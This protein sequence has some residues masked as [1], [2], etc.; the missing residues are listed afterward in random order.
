MRRE[1]DPLMGVAAGEYEHRN[2]Q[3]DRDPHSASSSSIIGPPAPLVTALERVTALAMP[4]DGSLTL[5]HVR[6]IDPRH[7]SAWHAADAA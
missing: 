1:I 2:R 5:S 7:L 4:R 3:D 6:A